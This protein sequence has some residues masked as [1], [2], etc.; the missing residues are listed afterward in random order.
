MEIAKELGLSV[1]AV[2]KRRTRI[3]IKLRKLLY[4]TVE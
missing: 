2:K 3:M 1:D 4:S